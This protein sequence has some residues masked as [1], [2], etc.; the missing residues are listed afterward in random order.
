[1]GER[2]RFL[3]FSFGSVQSYNYI[4]ANEVNPLKDE[5]GRQCAHLPSIETNDSLEG[6]GLCVRRM[7]LGI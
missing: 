3:T 4:T 5:K 1:M 7:G 2:L 6:E